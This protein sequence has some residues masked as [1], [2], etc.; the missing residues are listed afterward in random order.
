M[1]EKLSTEPPV[2]TAEIKNAVKDNLKKIFPA[3]LPQNVTVMAATKTV[4]PEIIN[5]AVTECGLRE[6]RRKPRSGA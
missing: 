3:A 6:Y 5:Y 4:A 2:L 1:T